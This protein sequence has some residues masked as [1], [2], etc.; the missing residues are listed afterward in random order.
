MTKWWYEYV[1]RRAWRRDEERLDVDPTPRT[2]HARKNKRRWCRGKVGVEH[3]L[4][5][6]VSTWGQQLATRWPDRKPCFRA[7]WWPSRWLCQHERYCV[8][9]GK[10]IHHTL[11]VECPDFTLDV[12]RYRRKK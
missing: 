12:T 4:A 2:P 3:V 7:E 6:R 10:I 8:T 5:V 9:C 11:D 1:E